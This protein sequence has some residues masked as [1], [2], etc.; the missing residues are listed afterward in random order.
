M[1]NAIHVLQTTPITTM[2][3]ATINH[4]VLQDTPITT[5]ASAGTNHH[6]LQDTPII[7][8]ASA[9][10]NHHVLQD[11][12]IITMVIAGINQDKSDECLPSIHSLFGVLLH[13]RDLG[14]IKN[15]YYEKSFSSSPDNATAPPK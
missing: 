7:T 10:I 11:T 5:M 1:A 6:V 15:R 12:P 4:H 13:L 9:T 14:Q 3:S 8:M 2:A